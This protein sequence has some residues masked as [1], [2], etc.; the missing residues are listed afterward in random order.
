[1]TEKLSF[2]IVIKVVTICKSFKSPSEFNSEM[3]VGK[4]KVDGDV[5]PVHEWDMAYPQ[6]I[7]SLKN[8]IKCCK[9][10]TVGFFLQLSKMPNSTSGVICRAK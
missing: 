4:V 8:Q 10:F 9:N 3:H 6:E 2:N 1:M 5:L 7:L